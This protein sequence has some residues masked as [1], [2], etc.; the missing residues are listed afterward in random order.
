MKTTIENSESK[1]KTKSVGGWIAHTEAYKETKS[2]RREST[3]KD[4][5]FRVDLDCSLL[6]AQPK[7]KN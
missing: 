6:N 7:I 1:I 5:N 3:L 4:L 2:D